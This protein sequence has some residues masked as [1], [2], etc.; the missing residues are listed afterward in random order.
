MGKSS[1]NNG[2][3]N[4]QARKK[5]RI[6]LTCVFALIAVTYSIFIYFVIVGFDGGKKE[7]VVVGFDNRGGKEN[8]GSAPLKLRPRN[9]AQDNMKAQSQ[10]SQPI[11]P[12]TPDDFCGSCKFRDTDFSCT[13]RI[14]WVIKNKKITMKE[15]IMENLKYCLKEGVQHVET[16]NS[17]TSSSLGGR[18]NN[19]EVAMSTSTPMNWIMV[20]VTEYGAIGDNNTDNTDAF[21]AA[22]EE[23][24]KAG[25]GELLVPSGGVYQTAPITLGPHTTLTVHGTIRGVAD[26]HKFPAIDPLPSFGRD[27]DF[28]VKRRRQALVSARHAP[29]ITIRGDGVIDGAGWYWYPFFLNHTAANYLGRPH[30]IE[31]E[32]CT[33]VEITGVTLRD[34]AF[35]T[36]HPVYCTDVYIHHMTID[37]PMCRNY[38][39]PNTDGIDIHS[40]QNVLVEYNTIECGDDH[41]TIL[42][43]K[44]RHNRSPPTRNVTVQHNILG[45]GMGLAIGSSTSGGVSDVLYYNNT[46]TQI[47]GFGQGQGAHIKMRM[48]YGGYVKNI[49][50]ID[51]TFYY[52]NGPAVEINSGYQSGSS[53]KRTC[54]NSTGDLACT[55]VDN[56][57]IKNMVVHKARSGWHVDCFENAPCTN[58]HFENITILEEPK[59]KKPIMKCGNVASGTVVGSDLREMFDES[60]ASLE[61]LP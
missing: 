21:H 48:R 22:I 32:N 58:L 6:S 36:L 17:K 49:S 55:E 1:L 16:D 7:T 61:T 25:G 38:R 12:N 42:A 11:S 51:N 20:D 31:I 54:T 18:K 30:I 53:W 35:W 9:N 24:N 34:P 59:T 40:C 15:A 43:G 46:M 27:A 28:R 41:V 56:I 57:T 50:W 3:N 26:Q 39:C 37:A 52:V 10:Q 23:L 5:K 2:R 19:V 13:E 45:R 47:S 29:N 44:L 60:C 33:G 8:D 4:T 14:D